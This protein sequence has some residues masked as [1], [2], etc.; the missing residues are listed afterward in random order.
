M[1]DLPKNFNVSALRSLANDLA[2][3][4]PTWTPTIQMLRDAAD[5]LEQCLDKLEGQAI[6]ID[7]LS[8]KKEPQLSDNE[9]IRRYNDIKNWK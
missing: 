5:E 9:I 4:D 6:L 7:L 8:N 1:T 3:C 2:V